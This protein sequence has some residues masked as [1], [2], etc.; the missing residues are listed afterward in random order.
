MADDH[1][2]RASATAGQRPRPN[3]DRRRR[4][5]A[6][7]GPHP[8]TQGDE[9]RLFER[10]SRERFDA[11][12]LWGMPYQMRK[13][14]LGASH[15]SADNGRVLAGVFH[16]VA[17]KEFMCIAFARDT[18][19]R[20]RPFQRSNFLPSARAG[21]LALR[22]DF[23]RALLTAH[24]EFSAAD[25]KA[26][27]VDLFASLENIERHQDAYVML[28]DGFNQ[29]AARSLLEEISRWIPDLDGNLVRDFQ[30]SGYSARVWELYLWAALR[31]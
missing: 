8:D 7:I 31:G 30:T 12:T 4:R 27:G 18:A 15:W 10:I 28:R 11:L 16:L 17:T 29:G 22:R 25:A 26:E 20:Y 6:M 2:S 23:G 1:D 9:H 24:P 3:D 5:T 14:T 21:E 13:E 19:G